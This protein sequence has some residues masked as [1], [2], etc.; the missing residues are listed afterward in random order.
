M[1]NMTLPAAS[2]QAKSLVF[3]LTASYGVRNAAL[4]SKLLARIL[5][6]QLADQKN[7][8]KSQ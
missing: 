5:R 8:K 2:E 3:K 7:M 6:K 1:K 4:V